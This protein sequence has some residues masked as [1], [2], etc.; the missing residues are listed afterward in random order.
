MR[1]RLYLHTT[2]G[3]HRAYVMQLAAPLTRLVDCAVVTAE[4]GDVLEGVRVIPGITAID[5]SLRGQ[6]RLLDRATT[7]IRQPN[8]LERALRDEYSPNEINICHIQELPSVAPSRMVRAAHDAGYLAVLTVHNVTP[9][10]RT[11]VSRLRHHGARAAWTSADRCITHTEA[12]KR[13]LLSS[14]GLLSSQ[15]GVVPHPIWPVRAVPARRAKSEFLFF[16]NLRSNK[17][18]DHFLAALELLDNPTATIAGSGSPRMIDFIKSE[19][20]RLGLTRCH[21]RPGFV[22]DSELPTM[23]GSHEVLVCPYTHFDAQS[24]ITHLAASYGTA[25]VVTD[26]GGLADLCRE[27]G[28]GEIAARP[29][30]TDIAKAMSKALD[31]VRRG[32]YNGRFERARAARSPGVIAQQLIGEYTFASRSLM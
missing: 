14:T 25:T 31:E 3:G 10:T 26:Q 5:T 12:L 21:F 29:A 22:P 2:D 20:Q 15:V 1:V 19:L 13:K 7:Y 24:G 32:T 18:I 23:F 8:E 30:G 6:R 17:G 16:G 28:L 9:H 27:F 4:G 11:V